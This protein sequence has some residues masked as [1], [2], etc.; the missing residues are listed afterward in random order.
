MNTTAP[1][2]HPAGH[3][4]TLTIERLA[5]AGVAPFVI[6]ALLMWLVTP[7]LLPFVALALTG[8][9]AIVASFLGGIHWGIALQQGLDAPRIHYIWGV[10]PSLLAWVAVVMPAYAGLPLLALLL[11]VCYLV[12]RKTWTSPQLRPWLTLRFR[13][14]AIATLSCL[15]GAS[16]T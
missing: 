6:L 9:A 2:P 16:N 7:D 3:P 8:Y 4:L 14:T 1:T 12:D 13:L 5:Y 10:V 11:L 15:L